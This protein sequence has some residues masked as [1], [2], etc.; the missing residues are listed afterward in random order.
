MKK[1][2][3]V[4]MLCIFISSLPGCEKTDE[5]LKALDK[6]KIV[7]EDIDKK[8]KEFKDKVQS[9]IPGLMGAEKKSDVSNKEGREDK[10]D[11]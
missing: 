3:V 6:A 2:L 10:K 5:A 4:I 11:E 8:T 9:I 1:M 7:K